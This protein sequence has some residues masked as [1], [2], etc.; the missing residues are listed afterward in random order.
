MN[1][2]VN[3]FTGS[4]FMIREPDGA[5]YAKRPGRQRLNLCLKSN[6]HYSPSATKLWVP[7]AL[8]LIV[9]PIPVSQPNQ[10]AYC[11][12][13]K[14]TVL[15]LN[16][17][18]I[19]CIRLSWIVIFERLFEQRCES[20]LNNFCSPIYL[21]IKILSCLTML[22]CYPFVKLVWSQARMPCSV[23][24]DVFARD[25]LW[26]H[27]RAISLEIMW[28]YILLSCAVPSHH[29][30]ISVSLFSVTVICALPPFLC[31]NVND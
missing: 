9:L 5:Y 6:P 14:H 23:F 7:K 16:M 30:I 20:N 10:S 8:Q 17:N 15:I 25:W 24:V 2:L 18:V 3:A 21:Q 22:A 31:H 29:L 11:Y 12:K 27:V 26:R 4:L 28:P 13:H 19:Y 1:C